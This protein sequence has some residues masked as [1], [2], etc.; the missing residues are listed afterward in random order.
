MGVLACD[1][2]GCESIMCNLLSYKFGYICSDCYEELL[3]GEWDNEDI[4]DFMMTPKKVSHEPNDNFK[5][6]VEDEFRNIYEDT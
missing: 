4:G 1:R 5:K 3:N 2:I 6:E